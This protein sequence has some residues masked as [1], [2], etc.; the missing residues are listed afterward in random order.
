M[1]LLIKDVCGSFDVIL[2]KTM[3]NIIKKK[4]PNRNGDFKNAALIPVI[5][6]RPIN[7]LPSFVMDSREKVS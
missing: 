4:S 2:I 5:M 1:I 3:I 7:H 6:Q